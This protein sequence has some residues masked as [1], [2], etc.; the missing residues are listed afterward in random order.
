[1]TPARTIRSAVAF[2]EDPALPQPDVGFRCVRD[3]K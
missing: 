2:S 3:I 1:M